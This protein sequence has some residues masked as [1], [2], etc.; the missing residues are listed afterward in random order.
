MPYGITQ[1]YLPTGRGDIPAFTPA[2]A[3]VVVVVSDVEVT[4]VQFMTDVSQLRKMQ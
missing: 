4:A 1:C 3:G 2:C